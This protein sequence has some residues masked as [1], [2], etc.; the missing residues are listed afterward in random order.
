MKQEKQREKEQ[1]AEISRESGIYF[2]ISAK[3]LLTFG[4][5]SCIINDVVSD[6]DRCACGSR[7][8]RVADCPSGLCFDG[9]YY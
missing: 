4:S 9:K 5:A 2:E 1:N 3:C 8:V 6:R 7:A